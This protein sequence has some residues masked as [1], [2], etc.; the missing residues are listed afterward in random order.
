MWLYTPLSG[1]D[2]FVRLEDL[3]NYSDGI[4]GFWKEYISTLS[5]L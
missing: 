3:K 4:I 1:D 2:L 5:D